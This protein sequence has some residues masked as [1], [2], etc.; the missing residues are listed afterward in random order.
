MTAAFTDSLN[1]TLNNPATAPRVLSTTRRDDT[2]IIDLYVPPELRWFEGHFAE[3]ALLPGVVQTT[4]VVE[5]GRRHF[6]L[7]PHFRAMNNMKFMRFIL[8]GSQVALQLR[9]DAGRRELFFEY[10]E[11]AA[12]CASGR[13]GFE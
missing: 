12:V 13:V 9:Y 7:P 5:F 3:L 8:P 6:D 1:D 4:W 10:R 11:G 2:V